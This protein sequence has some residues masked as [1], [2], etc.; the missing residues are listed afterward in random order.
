MSATETNAKLSKK[1]L[2]AVILFGTVGQIAWC[3]ENSFLNLY[4]YRT[5]TTDLLAVSAMVAASAV[6]A[7]ATTVIMGWVIDR[8]G[9]RRPFMVYGYMLWGVSVMIFSVFSVKNMQNVFS[10]DRATAI[11]L[12]S[13]GMVVMDCIMTFF[14]S[15]ANDAAFNAYVTDHTTKANRGKIEAL[16]SV[17][18][19]V[20]YLLLYVPFEIFGVT[21]TK[22]YDA[23]GNQVPSR[24]EGGSEVLGNWT[25]FYCL[26]GGVVLVAGIIG[27]FFLKDSPSVKPKKDLGFKELFY[28]FRPSVIKRNKFLYLIMAVVMLSY[29]ANNCFGNFMA[30]YLQN[31]LKCDEYVT[32][33][34]LGYLLPWGIGQGLAV[35]AGIVAGIVLDKMKNKIA[36]IIPG[37]I[38]SCVGSVIMFFASP[39]FFIIGV[40]MLILFCAG[41]FIQAMGAAFISVVCLSGIRNL[42][43]PDKVGRFQ[44]VRMVFVVMLPMCIGSIISGAV[45]SSDRYISGYDEFG[46]AVYT[47]PPIMFILAAAVVLLALIPTIALMKATKE[48]LTVPAEG[49]VSSDGNEN[50]S[51]EKEVAAAE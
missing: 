36:L 10:V 8:T 33:L 1:T 21:K 12:A 2:F 35:I 5:I 39:D 48:Q 45:S 43:P 23:A 46:H 6:V 20:A 38:S 29:M 7:T 28:G 14:G 30:I 26:L 22:F 9:K 15:T 11:V 40:P 4:V 51:I 49:V 25:L 13:V 32:F 19:V 18:A 31:T 17:L 3:I 16:L 34:N 47:C 27:L 50:L 44:G 42:T 24:V 41:N 37:I